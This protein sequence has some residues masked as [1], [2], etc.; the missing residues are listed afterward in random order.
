MSRIGTSMWLG[1]LLITPVAVVGD[2][3]TDWNEVTLDA[4]RI[5]S[6][7]PPKASR[8]LA[9]VHAAMYDAVNA[10]EGTHEA[11]LVE[12]SPPAGTSAEAA[13]ATAAHDVLA[14]LFADL[15]TEFDAAL[16]GSLADISDGQSKDD[17]IAFGQ[18]VAAQVLAARADDHSADVLEYAPSGEVGR[19]APTP[20]ALAAAL[21][22]NWPS[23]TPFAMTS[24]FQFRGGGP[25]DLA[26]DEYAVA[27]NEAKEIGRADSATRTE[28]Q[29]EIAQ[30]WI[31]GG[32]T[33]TPPGHWN[34]IAQ[35][36]AEGQ[37]NDLAKNARLFALLNIALA[38][39]AIA[40][41]DNKYAY[42]HWRPVTAIPAAANDGNDATEAD[43]DWLPLIPTPP[44]P[45]YTSGHST[46]SG[47]GS[48]ILEQFFGTDEIEFTVNSDSTP[49]VF[50]TFDSFSAAADESGQ[51]RIYGGI[52]WQ[53]ANQDGLRSGRDLAEYVYA[54][55]LTAVEAA[56]ADEDGVADDAD[57]CPADANAD[58]ANGDE[59]GVGD[60]CDNCPDDANA[61]QADED[62]DGH[63]DVCDADG[64][65]R[66][67]ICGA[68]NLLNLAG[69]T[70]LLMMLRAIPVRRRR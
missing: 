41:W 34:S 19:W 7:N 42:D 44:F 12:A 67:R 50:R 20:P 40:S 24:G 31:N 8:A 61:D 43:A 55:F 15:L 46:F 70:G 37:A 36:I 38:D 52:H 25:P 33:A 53:Y 51:S 56:D 26:S 47:A 48:K 59:D 16:A 23:V 4:I 49:E 11:Y 39:A 32:A 3:I 17:G 45:E 60:V 10:I 22:P 9:M 6:T 68:F 2:V 57:N 29:T 64:G 65:G 1:F 5:T 27:F 13:A 14:A 58:Q 54:N 69:L 21:L 28:E 66:P 18:S 35:L 30:F 62:D 63:G